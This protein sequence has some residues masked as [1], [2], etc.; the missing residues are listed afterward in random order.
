[1]ENLN[2]RR[3]TSVQKALDTQNT[4]YLAPIFSRLFQYRQSVEIVDVPE[5][6]SWPPT[7]RLSHLVTLFDIN[8]DLYQYSFCPK[9]QTHLRFEK[10]QFLEKAGWI[11]HVGLPAGLD[12]QELNDHGFEFSRTPETGLALTDEGQALLLWFW[13]AFLDAHQTLNLLDQ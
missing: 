7:A 3:L 2:K 13:L 4:E 1:M 6:P 12:V 9:W 8:D 5:Q 10:I 11:V